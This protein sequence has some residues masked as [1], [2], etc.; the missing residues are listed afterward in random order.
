MT[1]IVVAYGTLQ[2]LYF[3]VLASAKLDVEQSLVKVLCKRQDPSMLGKP[4]AKELRNR[5]RAM[6]WNLKFQIASADSFS[7]VLEFV[8]SR[9]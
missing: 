8:S 2:I 7:P 6:I 9:F 1:V 4:Y 3:E 5:K